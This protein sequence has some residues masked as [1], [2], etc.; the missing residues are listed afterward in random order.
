MPHINKSWSII[1]HGGAKDISPDEEQPN[2]EGLQE[3]I[4]IGSK[5]LALGGSALDAVE[6]AVKLLEKNPAYN[7]G[8][9]GCVKNEDGMVNLDASIMDGET[10]DIG[11]V[12]GLRNIEHPVSVARALLKEKAI[13]LIGE[14]ANKFAEQKGFQKL[15][16]SALHFSASKGCD[17][18]GCV[19]L[20]IHGNL[21]AATSTGGLEAV[22]AGRVGDVP[23]PGCGFYADNAR[24][25]VSASGE[26][27]S[28]A[29][30]T[31]AAE[32]LHF[33]KNTDPNEAIKLSLALLERVKGEA[34]LIAITP[35]G[36]ICW[37]HNS[38]NFAIG[39]ARINNRQPNIY[40]KKS[41]EK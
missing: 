27:E 39:Y 38:P 29:R 15:P 8:L 19:A 5:I 23:L 1:A 34:G 41:E 10:L 13:F 28:I 14:G 7:A 22:R 11:A 36:E 9:Y 26:G 32:F 24:G 4:E 12:A 21:A 17:T 37:G 3:A 2:R 6:K 20:D 18:V 30:V 16:D 35:N 31:L 33:L 40:L 25:A